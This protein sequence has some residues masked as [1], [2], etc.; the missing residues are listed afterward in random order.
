LNI[1]YDLLDDGTNPADPEQNFGL[2]QMDL[3]PK[4]AAEVL[5]LFRQLAADKTIE[6]FLDVD[7]RVHV[8]AMKG[9]NGRT[10]IIWTELGR[11]VSVEVPAT[12]Q[13]GDIYGQPVTIGPDRQIAVSEK[14]LVV[15]LN[16]SQ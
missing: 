2:Y 8:F 12:A 13:V 7:P 10:F 3:L 5:S 14:P 4:P 15:W 16:T 9:P 6:G 1:V 11:P